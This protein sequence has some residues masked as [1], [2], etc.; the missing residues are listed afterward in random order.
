MHRIQQTE[1]Q[2]VTK[3]SQQ[4]EMKQENGQRGKWTAWYYR[5]CG[6]V[7]FF[8]VAAA[9]FNGYY[10]KY[11]LLDIDEFGNMHSRLAFEPMIDG[12]ADRPF[13][14][15]QLLPMTANWINRRV[16]SA[17]QDRLY[18][19]YIHIG[20]INIGRDPY[21]S[22]V[23][24]DP[25]YFFRYVTVYVTVFLFAWAAVYA[26]FHL[27]QAVGNSPPC[28]AIASMTMILLFPYFLINAGFYYDYPE[29][30]F[31]AVV[32]W[33]ALKVD[34]WWILPVAALATWN[35]ESFLS[36]TPALYPLLRQRATRTAAIVRTGAILLTCA[37]VYEPLRI[38]FRHNGGSTVETHISEQ[39]QALLHPATLMTREWDYGLLALQGLNPLTIV[40]AVGTVWLGWSRLTR[41]VQRFTLFCLCINGPLFFLFCAPGELRDLSML[42]VPMLLLIA[43]NLTQWEARAIVQA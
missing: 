17:T 28:A 19:R 37:A 11:R 8:V 21:D 33:M 4:A 36:F 1:R 18:K 25:H 7:L 9:S 27:A 2:K 15:R 23:L 22:P 26:M 3:I 32:V 10:D 42:Y 39:I 41:P 35:K 40:L 43:A 14:Y 29:L 24:H 16:S 13:V 30:F 20:G 31:F 12:T 38:R 34:G 6:L 5:I